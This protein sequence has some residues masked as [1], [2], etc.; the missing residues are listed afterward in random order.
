MNWGILAPL[1]PQWLQQGQLL[2]G[3]RAAVTPG[4]LS[5]LAASQ[6]VRR[7]QTELNLE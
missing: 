2:G 3:A 7:V 1:A 6:A 5:S 4:S